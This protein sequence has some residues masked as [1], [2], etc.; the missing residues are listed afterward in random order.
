M[1]G[2]RNDEQHHARLVCAPQARAENHLTHLSVDVAQVAA[3]GDA[4]ADELIHACFR[5]TTRMGGL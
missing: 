1:R 2:L 4:V 5:V 3:G